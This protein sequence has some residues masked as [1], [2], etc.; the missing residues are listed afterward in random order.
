MYME[1]GVKK[2]GTAGLIKSL[3]GGVSFAFLELGFV[4]RLLNFKYCKRQG[5]SCLY[6]YED[7]DENRN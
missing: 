7:C 3:E 4:L 5:L 6:F 2:T 1:I